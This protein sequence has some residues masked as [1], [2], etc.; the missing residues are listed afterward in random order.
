[1]PSRL[2]TPQSETPVLQA[3]I[4]LADAE[5]IDS[6]TLRRV[7]H[8]VD[9]PLTSMQR[10]FRSRDRLVV[11]MVEYVFSRQDR[12][13]GEAEIPQQRLIRLAQQEWAAYRAHPWLVSVMA[14]TRPPLAP[15]VLNLTRQ[16]V[17]AFLILGM[18][19]ATALGRYLALNAYTQGMALLL[20]SED[21][22]A[23]AWQQTSQAWWAEEVD[24][25]NRTGSPVSAQWIVDVSSNE[26]PDP[27]AVERWF[28]DGLQRIITGLVGDDA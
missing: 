8:L 6:V 16:Y 11:A 21:H 10:Q 23:S 26:M 9:A 5:G 19:R 28:Q 27:A 20:V 18:D 22:E 2:P 4:A 12:G 1:M 24:R 14:R 3:A 15:A 7:G 13:N 17:D 25:L